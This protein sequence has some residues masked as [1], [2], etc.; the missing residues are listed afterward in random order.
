MQKKFLPCINK[1]IDSTNSTQEIIVIA[2]NKRIITS[3]IKKY[4]AKLFHRDENIFIRMYNHETS[5][6]V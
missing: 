5:R 6:V 4:Y 3:D 1:V 2:N